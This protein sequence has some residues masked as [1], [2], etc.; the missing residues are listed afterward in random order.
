MAAERDENL[1]ELTLDSFAQ[2]VEDKKIVL[3]KLFKSSQ[4]RSEYERVVMEFVTKYIE[5]I[6]EDKLA[7]IEYS[8]KSM[9]KQTI[10]VFLGTHWE[11]I[12]T[13]LYYDFVKKCVRRMGLDPIYAEDQDFM[14]KIFE[15]LAFRVMQHRRLRVKS[16]E[17][18]INLRNCTLEI[19]KDGSLSQ[20]EHRASDFFTYVLPF[21]YDTSMACP[22]WHAFL[23]RVLPEMDMQTLLAEYIGY[24]FTKDLKLEKMAVFYGT[25]SNG[26]SVCLDVIT[27]LFGG[28][29]N[30]SNI[31]LSSLTND[32]EKRAHIEHK[33]VNISHESGGELDAAMVKQLTSGEPTEVRQLY[34]GSHTMVE[35][36]KFITSYNNLPT[37][38]N[39]YGFFR[40]WLLFPFDVTI[41]EDEQDIDLTSKLCTELSGIFNWV[42]AALIGL[43][44]RKTFTKSQKCIDALN[45]YK[46]NSRSV[47]QF[48]YERCEVCNGQRLKLSDLY[49]A[50]STYCRE[51][52]LPNKCGKKSFQDALKSFGAVLTI[53]HKQSMYNV[54]F[55]EI[56][57]ETEI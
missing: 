41:P 47:N 28:L 14:N 17:I 43:M 7:V 25:G 21:A 29:H 16:G 51:E 39:T 34:V 54:R 32:D 15:R 56:S 8:Q 23:D 3:G 52:E 6:V 20:R 2:R 30:V 26:K 38:E 33:L 42:L 24:C 18:W 53:Y 4:R 46:R 13:Q 49:S 48:L 50:Y 27:Q 57:E 5:D 36:A 40:R 35:Y 9:A 12:I 19:R 37:A 1:V 55:K 44:K 11:L 22:Q 45:E 31:S 10:Y